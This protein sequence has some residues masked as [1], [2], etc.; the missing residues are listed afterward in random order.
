MENQ[1]QRGSAEGPFTPQLLFQLPLSSN[2]D[3]NQLKAVEIF[4][5]GYRL[6]S[7]VEL[8]SAQMPEAGRIPV[9]TAAVRV[10]MIIMLTAVELPTSTRQGGNGN[11][12]E[13]FCGLDWVSFSFSTCKKAGL[14]WQSSSIEAP[15]QCL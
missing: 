7:N 13:T 10:K 15:G 11:S 3:M 1:L 6:D 14:G 12:K 5:W 4:F 2:M 9:E 8:W